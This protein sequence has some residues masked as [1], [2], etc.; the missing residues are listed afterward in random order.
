M[1]EE[2]RFVR[3]EPG[4]YHAFY[5]AVVAALRGDA[6]PPVAADDAVAGLAV[7]EAA[8]RS[9]AEGRVVTLTEERAG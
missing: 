5:A 3:T 2:S 6:P 7:L 8:R 1:S 4:A 9:A